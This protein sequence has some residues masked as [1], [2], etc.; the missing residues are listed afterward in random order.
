ML[1]DL[2]ALVAGYTLYA[3]QNGFAPDRDEARLAEALREARE[4]AA[5]RETDE[6]A[7]LFFALSRRPRA[8]GK[9]HGRMTLH[10]TVE[11]ARVLG[12]AFAVDLA[13]LEL[14]RARILRRAIEFEE[15]CAWFIAH[16]AP[17]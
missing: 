15:L 9:A 10:L 7:A 11:H 12:L 4:L 3:K 2:D 8:F 17:V 16:L 6:P 13:V 5:A 14:L 1:P